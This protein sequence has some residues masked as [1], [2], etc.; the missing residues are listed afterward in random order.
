MGASPQTM[1]LAEQLILTNKEKFDIKAI[2]GFSILSV[3]EILQ[4]LTIDD[5]EKTIGN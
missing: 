1:I 3:T 2:P 4:P 5:N